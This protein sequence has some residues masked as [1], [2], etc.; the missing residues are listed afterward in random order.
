MNTCFVRNTKS[1]IARNNFQPEKIIEEDDN[2][3]GKLKQEL[4]KL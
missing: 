2:T 3:I 4:K 1:V